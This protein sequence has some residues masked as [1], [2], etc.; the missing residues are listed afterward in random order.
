M[1]G[2]GAPEI[3]VARRLRRCAE[4][5]AGRERLAVQAFAEVIEVIPVTLVENA[6][7]DP[8][9]TLCARKAPESYKLRLIGI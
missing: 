3:E 8:I 1:V 9:D 5:T 6:G 4:G 7:L 2:G